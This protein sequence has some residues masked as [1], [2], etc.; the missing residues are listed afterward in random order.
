MPSPRLITF[1]CYGTLID[2]HG[3]LTRALAALDVPGADLNHLAQRY[4]EIEME[5]EEGPYMR[6]GE[7]MACTLERLL[8]EAGLPLGEGRREI[9]G[10]SLPDWEPFAE[11]REVL[12][13]LAK[14][15]S[16]AILSNIDDDLLDASLRKIGVPFAHRVTAEQ[17]R[18][19]KPRPAH[20]QRIRRVSQLPPEEILH[21]GASLL[22]DMVP[23]RDLGI[24]H[25]WINRTADEVPDWMEGRSL[26]DLRQLPAFIA[27]S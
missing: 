8:E 1:D 19:Y 7:V 13:A 20:F 16:L 24:P 4:V 11:T 9:L 23:A 10:G 21:V 3:G 12:G 14:E 15:R 17:V 26:P 27:A 25:V 18:S 6:Y 2:W 5:I 22:H